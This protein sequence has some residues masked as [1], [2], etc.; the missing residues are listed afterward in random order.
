MS[1]YLSSGEFSHPRLSVYQNFPG[2]AQLLVDI[3]NDRIGGAPLRDNLRAVAGQ[4]GRG[5]GLQSGGQ[6]NG[7]IIGIPR[8]GVP[9]AEG[10]SAVFPGYS[11]ALANDGATRDSGR[12]II[13]DDLDMK[14]Q[15][16]ILVA[17]SVIVTGKTIAKTVVALLEKSTDP[18]NITVFSAFAA[19]EGL[20]ALLKIFPGLSINIGSFAKSKQ[21]FDLYRFQSATVLDGIS[22]LGELV[23]RP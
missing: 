2:V 3:K 21:N 12:P 14:R 6:P 19:A 17:D 18:G 20:H 10:L 9:M 22:N 8:S 7:T 23:S 16:N 5:W 11:Y 4:M 13:P 15:A 1:D